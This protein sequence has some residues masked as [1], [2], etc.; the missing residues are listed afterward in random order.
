[1][2]KYTWCLHCETVHLTK[3]WEQHGKEKGDTIDAVHGLCPNCVAGGFLDGWRWSELVKYNGYPKE[4]KIG[5]E[6][7]LYPTDEQK[8]LLSS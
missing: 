4:P 8:K 5:H 1:M 3:S 6:Y 2:S 7:P